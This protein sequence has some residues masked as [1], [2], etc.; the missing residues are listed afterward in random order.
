MPE[1]L[2]MIGHIFLVQMNI[3]LIVVNF[4]KILAVKS[5]LTAV[6][7]TIRKN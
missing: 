7:M 3:R 1:S 5:V 4:A 6:N 2:V